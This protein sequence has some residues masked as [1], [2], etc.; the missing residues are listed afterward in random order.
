MEMNALL[1]PLVHIITCLYSN[2]AVLQFNTFKISF[3]ECE[4]KFPEAQICSKRLYHDCS[5]EGTW[6]SCTIAS[7]QVEQGRVH[8][9]G[10]VIRQRGRFHANLCR[11]I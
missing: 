4:Q 5:R 3:K 6:S 2:L 7:W 11:G 10:R 8:Y 1:A 9:V